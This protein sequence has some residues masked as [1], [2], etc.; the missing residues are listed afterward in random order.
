MGAVAAGAI[1]LA[2]L[3]V[4]VAGFVWQHASISPGGEPVAYLVEEAAGFVHE[5]LSPQAA[6]DLKEW[7]VRRILEF[8]LYHNQVVAPRRD[9]RP[10]VVGSG[11]AIEFVMEQ[12]ALVGKVYEPLLI[13]EVMAAEIEYLEAI[14][15]VGAPVEDGDA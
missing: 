1:L 2:L 10:P 13:A 7:D 14:G 4:V 15:A 6:S 8:G 11:D 5:R 3:M 9:G 12:A